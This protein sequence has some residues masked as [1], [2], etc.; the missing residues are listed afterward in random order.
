MEIPKKDFYREYVEHW[1]QVDPDFPSLRE[2]KKT[3][4]ASEFARQVDHLAMAL[5]HL[6]I[7]KGDRIVTILPNGIDYVLVLVA[8]GKVGAITVPLDVKFKVA[9][10]KRFLSHAEP[11]LI[12]TVPQ[13]QDHNIVESL[14]ALGPD[15]QGIRKITVGSTVFGQSFEQ[16]F[17]M[18]LDLQSQ[19]DTVKKSLDRDEGAVVVFTGGT[20]GVP[21]AAL[22]SHYNMALMSFLD[23]TC[24][25][26]KGGISGR[27]KNLSCLPP[28]HV[29]GTVEFNG[30][31]IVGGME[32]IMLDYWSPTEVLEITQRERIPWVGGVPTMFAIFLAMP[33]LGDYDLSC[34]KMAVCSG[35]KIPLELLL[36]IKQYIAPIVISGY[37]STESGAEVTLTEPDADPQK[38]ANGY[39]GKPLPTVKLKIVDD[40]GNN[41]PQGEVGEVLT[42][43]PLGIPGY[44]NMPEEDKAGFTG[45]GWVKSGDLGYLDEEGGLY[46]VGR[47]KQ[48]IRVGGY[49]ILPTEVEEVAMEHPAVAMAAAIGMPDDIYFEVVWLAVMPELGSTV[50][51]EEV[52][53]LCKEK[54][55]KFKVP[56]K[57]IVME[58]LPFTRI[59]KVDRPTLKKLALA[60]PEA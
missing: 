57:I 22:L 40:E 37:G 56:K 33:N 32:M 20:T 39:A 10:L 1:A 17:Q 41:L 7:E 52:M 47:K 35:E 21:K 38:I 13:A 12:I 4:T 31:G 23:V 16:L 14:Q 2:G 44:F 36:G 46:I 43:G 24:M 29:G 58:M 55:A 8:A 9:D 3:V 5:I 60:H 27:T 51:E 6:G 30:S 45:D 59:G 28:S 25:L 11:A 42:A 18:P 54:L 50:N 53:L 19:L 26:E 49:N 48:I 34:L 15:F